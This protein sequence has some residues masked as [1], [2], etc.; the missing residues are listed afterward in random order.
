MPILSPVDMCAILKDPQ[1][2]PN[3]SIH[4]WPIA[5]STPN[6]D[7]LLDLEFIDY[8]DGAYHVGQV[9]SANFPEFQNVT[10]FDRSGFFNQIHLI[11]ESVSMGLGFTVLPSQAVGAFKAHKKVLVHQL[12][13]VVSETLYMGTHI[14]KR[15][16][17][18]VNTVIR[19]V[20]ECLKNI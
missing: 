4:I 6:W 2:A 8:P 9:L 16:P 3:T 19:E 13:N 5:V 20:E 11:L 7:Q 15:T 18:N 14:N 1:S 12:K 10:Q 17:N